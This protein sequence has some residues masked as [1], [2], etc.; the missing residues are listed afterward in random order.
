MKTDK[1]LIFFD[2]ETTGLDVSKDRIVE[3][4]VVKIIGNEEHGVM[5]NLLNPGIPISLE[6]TAIHG[7]TNE[8]VKDKPTFKD[9]VVDYYNVFSGCDL[10]GFNQVSFDVPILSEEFARCGY[11]FPDQDTKFVDVKTIF[12]KKEER[13]LSAAVKFYCNKVYANG[14]TDAHNAL[15]DVKATIDVFKSMKSIYMDLPN[16]TEELHNYCFEGRELVDFAGKLT[17]NEQGEIIFNF[18]KYFGKNKRVVDDLAYAKWMLNAD[19]PS[20]TKWHLER[21]IVNWGQE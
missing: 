2:L 17:K 12:H 9:M 7:I 8:M 16:T 20:N 5:N 14:H 18:G 10:A 19:F 4:A 15:A 11:M 13:T 3:I 1:P 21:I 6:A